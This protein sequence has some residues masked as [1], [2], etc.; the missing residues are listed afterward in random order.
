MNNFKVNWA[1]IPGT[2]DVKEIQD[3]EKLHIDFSKGTP[4]GNGLK[5]DPESSYM[6]RW[7]GRK[8]FVIKP[9]FMATYPVTIIQFLSFMNDGGYNRKEFWSVLGWKYKIKNNWNK[10]LNWDRQMRLYSNYPI[11]GVSWFE[12]EAFCKWMNL[13]LSVSSIRIP[14]EAEW[15]WVA[16]GPCG[17]KYP[18]I[19]GELKHRDDLKK[20]CN[21]SEELTPVNSF[22]ILSNDYWWKEVYLGQPVYDLLGNV[23]EW[24][25]SIYQDNYKYSNTSALGY[26]IDFENFRSMRGSCYNSNRDRFRSSVRI[27]NKFDSR[28][29]EAG[30]RIMSEI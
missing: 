21:I 25:S 11:T 27:M 22:D 3:R 13:Y 7:S 29:K 9:F 26:N 1:R 12:A 2:D 14:T 18:W 30:F 10:P 15:E 19:D 23:T 5:Y 16:R 4:L 8:P 24:N 6:E 28:F 20:Y 17:R